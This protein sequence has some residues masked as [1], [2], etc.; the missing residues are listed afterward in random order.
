MFAPLTTK[1]TT[2]ATMTRTSPT[3]IRPI[4][5]PRSPETPRSAV[6]AEEMDMAQ[7]PLRRILEYGLQS[8]P[9][10][11]PDG[12]PHGLR[13]LPQTKAHKNRRI[14]VTRV[15]AWPGLR[16]GG[17]FWSAPTCRGEG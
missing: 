15:T 10:A 5:S 17:K 7:I 6:D 3:M 2:P 16:E 1:K 8:I 14:G 12:K 11:A 4:Q 13:P 9:L